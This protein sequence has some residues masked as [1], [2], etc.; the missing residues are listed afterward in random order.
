MHRHSG[1]AFDE[2]SGSI[3]ENLS[4]PVCNFGGIVT[5]ADYRIG[6]QLP[7]V[8]EHQVIG[9]AASTLAELRV[10]RDVAAK[11]ALDRRAH[12]AD[13]RTRTHDNAADNAEGPY[14]AITRQIKCRRREWMRLA[15]RHAG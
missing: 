5:D 6:Y 9:I 12:I 1:R 2:Y 4:D 11:E 14:H 10:K 3:T 8:F 7:G 15:H 13:D